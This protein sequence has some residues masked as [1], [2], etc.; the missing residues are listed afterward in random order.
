[1]ALNCVANGKVLRDG[2][3][4]NIWV[5]P[6]AGDAGGAVGAALAAWHQFLGKER[7]ADGVHDAMDGALLGPGFAQQDVEQRLAEAARNS[8]SPP[9]KS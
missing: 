4:R 3:F 5:Q 7:S 8:P 1:M 6:A 2:S 9:T